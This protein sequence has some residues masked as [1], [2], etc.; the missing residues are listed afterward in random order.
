M[1]V[2][3]RLLDALRGRWASRDELGFD[4]GGNNPAHEYVGND[5]LSKMDPSGTVL[6][7]AGFSPPLAIGNPNWP[8]IGLCFQW[9]LANCASERNKI[10]S[11]CLNKTK[12]ALSSK[13]DWAK[14]AAKCA[15]SAWTGPAAYMSCVLEQ[16]LQDAVESCA[17]GAATELFY[18][19]EYCFLHH[20]GQFP[21][22]PTLWE[23]ENSL[24]V[25]GIADLDSMDVPVD[26]TSTCGEQPPPQSRHRSRPREKT[27]CRRLRKWRSTKAS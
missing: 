24:G 13:K 27:N 21:R 19:F 7:P 3:A 16:M 10:G 14:A 5:P 12:K 17:E 23:I 15:L 11:S 1:Y 20:G 9:V 18:I 2:R 8:R 25:P 22:L 4:G 6:I 26:I